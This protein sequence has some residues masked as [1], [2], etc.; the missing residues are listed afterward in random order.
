MEWYSNTVVM[1]PRD[2]ALE[3]CPL[4]AAEHMSRQR[5]FSWIAFAWT[6]ASNDIGFLS[7]EGHSVESL[8]IARTGN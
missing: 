6:A 5:W 2:R 1:W 7:K 8:S 4:P 3:G